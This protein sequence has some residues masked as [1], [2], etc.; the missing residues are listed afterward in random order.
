MAAESCVELLCCIYSTAYI[1][2][3]ALLVKL[4][5]ENLFGEFLD[6]RLACN[7][8][9]RVNRIILRHSRSL[10]SLVVQTTF[11]DLRLL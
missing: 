2:E 11:N 6:V 1:A 10:V 5:S 7:Q 8:I 3:I 4:H 9:D